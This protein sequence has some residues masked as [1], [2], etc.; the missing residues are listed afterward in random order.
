MPP[1]RSVD[2]F[3]DQEVDV[4]AIIL[5]EIEDRRISLK[6]VVAQVRM[7][8]P[9]LWRIYRRAHG[10]EKAVGDVSVRD[11]LELADVVDMSLALV[12]RPTN[13]RSRYV[14]AQ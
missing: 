2:Y 12:R 8:R 1:Q 5:N 4:L 11:V 10:D 13:Y 3:L 14:Q 7:S 9:K 6:D